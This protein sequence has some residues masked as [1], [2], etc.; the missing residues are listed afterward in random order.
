VSCFAA[1]PSP[2]SLQQAQSLIQELDVVHGLGNRMAFQLLQVK[3]ILAGE[4]VDGEKLG[5]ILTRVIRTAVL[6]EHNFNM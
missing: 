3:V 1:H 5:D 2:T 4:Q 6:S